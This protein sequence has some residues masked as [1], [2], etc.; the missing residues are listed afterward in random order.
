[1]VLGDEATADAA[2]AEGCQPAWIQGMSIRSEP[3]MAAGRDQVN[4]QTGRDCVADVYAQAG[5]TN[6]IEEIDAVECYVPFS[7]MSRCGWRT[8]ALLRWGRLEADRVGCHR[9]RREAAGEHVR[10]GV[11]VQPDRCVGHDPFR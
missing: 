5:I 6:P 8:W 9:P 10:R 7:G 3:A 4:P 2:A 11:V 1:M